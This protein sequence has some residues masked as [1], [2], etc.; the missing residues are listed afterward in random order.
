M[1]KCGLLVLLFSLLCG[2]FMVFDTSSVFAA[3]DDEFLN[4]HFVGDSSAYPSYGGDL[5][6]RYSGH[7]SYKNCTQDSSFTLSLPTRQTYYITKFYYESST[8]SYYMGLAWLGGEPLEFLIHRENLYS[9]GSSSFIY[10]D[11]SSA[12]GTFQTS[13]NTFGYTYFQIID[14]DSISEVF[15]M[16]SFSYS[17]ISSPQNDIRSDL[18]GTCDILITS[19]F[20]VVG[21]QLSYDS[22]LGH[23]VNIQNSNSSLTATNGYKDWSNTV[24]YDSITSSGYD[25]ALNNGNVEYYFVLQGYYA[26]A[27]GLGSKNKMID[28]ISS[29]HS[30]SEFSFT[31]NSDDWRSMYN[32]W[33][34]QNDLSSSQRVSSAVMSIWLRPTNSTSYGDWVVIKEDGSTYL[35]SSSTPYSGSS[36]PNVIESKPIGSSSSISNT[37]NGHSVNTFDQIESGDIDFSGIREGLGGIIDLV[38]DIPSILSKLFTWLPSWV[39]AFLSTCIALWGIIALIKLIRG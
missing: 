38:G 28:Y 12:Y 21:T 5:V 22:S 27:F 37:Q 39:I 3:T 13:S 20:D 8:Y 9:D 10:N 23:L 17:N 32:E 29:S 34:S 25:I 1:K 7:N 31:Y 4:Y 2:L 18:I 26:D 36:E 15:S 14:F 33:M 35:L 6:F 16:P 11:S 30:I 19:S 24:S